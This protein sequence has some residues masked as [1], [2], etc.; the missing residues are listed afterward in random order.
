MSS[1]PHQELGLVVS[2]PEWPLSNQQARSGSGSSILRGKKVEA[3]RPLEAQ[4]VDLAHYFCHLLMIKANHKTNPASG[5][6]EIDN[7]GGEEL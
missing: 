6:R 1:L 5:N 4:T 2:Q 3:A 7:S